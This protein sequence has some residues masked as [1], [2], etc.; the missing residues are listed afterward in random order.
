MP[1]IKLRP[2]TER[3]RNS[4]CTLLRASKRK[5]PILP[6]TIWC[7]IPAT[8]REHCTCQVEKQH[9]LTHSLTYP[10]THTPTHSLIHSLTHSSTHS[11]THSL[12]HPLT[13]SFT[14]PPSH[15]HSPTFPLSFT[16]SLT[17]PLTHSPTHSLTHPLTQLPT[18]PNMLH[19]HILTRVKKK[20]LRWSEQP[21]CDHHL[22]RA[23]HSPFA[24]QPVD[25]SLR[26]SFALWTAPTRSF[27]RKEKEQ[28]KR[29]CVE[30]SGSWTFLLIFSSTIPVLANTCARVYS[31]VEVLVCGFQVTK[32]VFHWRHTWLRE[33]WRYPTDQLLNRS[34]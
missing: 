26:L 28:N 10:L 17:H 23:Y 22:P 18:H 31:L 8:D 9:L 21:V 33:R 2:P 32:Y 6:Q 16:H 14:H 1:L 7:L 34:T 27:Y 30:E 12:I 20:S 29:K 5:L 19:V 15:F 13:H 4:A 25:Q 3:K 24:D 11:S